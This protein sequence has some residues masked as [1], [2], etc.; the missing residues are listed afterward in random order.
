[1]DQLLHVVR[2]AAGIDGTTP[3]NAVV[4][5]DRALT[6]TAQPGTASSTERARGSNRGL[7]PNHTAGMVTTIGIA[8]IWLAVTVFVTGNFTILRCSETTNGIREAVG[9]E[10]VDQ[11]VAI[12]V[13]AVVAQEFLPLTIRTDGAV[14]AETAA[15]VIIS[16]IDLA[17][18]VVVDAIGTVLRDTDAEGCGP[19]VGILA[20]DLAVTIV[21]G[22]VRAVLDSRSTRGVSRAVRVEAVCKSVTVVVEPVVADFRGGT[23]ARGMSR[24]LCI[25][26]IHETIGIIVDAVGAV[27]GT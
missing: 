27:L 5:S 22:E 23:N 18:A 12:I 10:A 21:V 8:T 9:I 6:R 16:A 20:I 13:E 3:L 4:I 24:A 17:V 19:A 7:V 2:V 14:A 25:V 26:A 1:M 11:A 15:A